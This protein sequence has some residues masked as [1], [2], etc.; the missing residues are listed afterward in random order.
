MRLF[1]SASNH[2]WY[3]QRE[4][5][6]RDRGKTWFFFFFFFFPVLINDLDYRQS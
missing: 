1:Q 5:G 6:D 2:S 4:A 3:V